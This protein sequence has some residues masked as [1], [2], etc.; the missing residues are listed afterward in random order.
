MIFIAGKS[1]DLQG[2]FRRYPANG[3]EHAC[4]TT[5]STSRTRYD[6]VSVD[7]LSFELTLRGAIVERSELLRRSGLQFE[8][9]RR[10]YCNRRYWNRRA[11]GGFEV[12]SGVSAAAAVRDIYEN[13]RAYGTECATAMQIVYYGALLDVVSEAAFD[14][15]FAGMRLMNWH[16]IAPTLREVGSMN[17]ATDYLAGDRRYFANP[18]VNLQ[19]PEWQGENVIDLG[20]GTYYGHGMGRRRAAEII[21]ELNQNRRAARGVAT[22]SADGGLRSAYLMDAAGRPDFAKLYGAFGV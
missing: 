13:G 17:R 18:D 4:L 3:V 5:L 16:D 7:E 15:R 22:R 20:D 11:D 14:R 10:A 21:A 1:A 6:Y 19:T 8:V 9:F 12:R 2:L